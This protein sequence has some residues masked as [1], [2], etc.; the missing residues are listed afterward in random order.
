MNQ[1]LRFLQFDIEFDVWFFLYNQ[2]LK[3]EMFSS[4]LIN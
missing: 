4:F 2:I 3:C 1:T